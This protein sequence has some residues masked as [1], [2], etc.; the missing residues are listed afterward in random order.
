VRF[1]GSL[2]GL[3]GLRA[4]RAVRKRKIYPQGVLAKRPINESFQGFLS[5]LC[6]TTSVSWLEIGH[7]SIT[8]FSLGTPTSDRSTSGDR[9][10]ERSGKKT[11]PHDMGS[12]MPNKPKKLRHKW[13]DCDKNWLA[14]ETP[15]AMQRQLRQQTIPKFLEG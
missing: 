5:V 14:A 6:D 10:K 9:Q 2:I 11:G 7:P 1:P 4:Y 15:K 13:S 12:N 3:A 8:L